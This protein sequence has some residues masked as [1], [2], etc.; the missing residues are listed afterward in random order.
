VQIEGVGLGR[1]RLDRA[2]DARHRE[3][4]RGMPWR[5]R[6]EAVAA[7]AGVLLL[8]ASVAVFIWSAKNWLGFLLLFAGFFC[9]VVLHF[10]NGRENWPQNWD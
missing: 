5:D 8:P 9:G 3:F 4:V 10:T 7:V 2:A 1:S 6:I